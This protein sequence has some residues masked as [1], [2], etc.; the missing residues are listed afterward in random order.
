[1]MIWFCLR[2]ISNNRLLVQLGADPNVKGQFGRTPLYRAAFAG[3]LHAV[4]V[5]EIKK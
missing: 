4:K 5:S 2:I 3:H 1:M